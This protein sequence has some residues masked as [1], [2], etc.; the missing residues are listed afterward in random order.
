[1]SNMRV[2]D[3]VKQPPKS[4]LKEIRGGRMNGKTDISPMWRIE[5]LTAVYGPC[6]TGWRYTI[7]K[8]WLE[9]GMHDKG[10]EITA[11]AIISLYTCEDGK[12]SEAVPGIGGSMFVAQE[13]NG[14]F[15]SD[16]AFKM[17]VTDAISVACKALGFAADI[18]AGRWDGSKYSEGAPAVAPEP[19][20]QSEES[21]QAE[22]A[23]MQW[24]DPAS[25]PDV[26]AYVL[27]DGFK[28]GMKNLHALD[29]AAYLRVRKVAAKFVTKK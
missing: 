28:A 20:K 17:A 9:N 6:G 4:A 7:D 8:L 29:E 16:E 1:M 12:W 24:L 15:T 13:K 5:A 10:E 27:T 18:Y 23:M 14:P 21:M 11:N 2:W 25:N 19:A 22:A 26:A 3:K